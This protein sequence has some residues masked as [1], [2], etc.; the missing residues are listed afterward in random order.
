MRRTT[1]WIALAGLLACGPVTPGSDDTGVGSSTSGGSPT[2]GAA[3]T[4][5]VTT[6]GGETGIAGVTSA[7]PSGDTAGGMSSD[8]FL[9]P[10]DGVVD[11]TCDVFK[12]NCPAGEKCMPYADDGGGS[13][14]NNKCVPVVE[15]PVHL[16]EPCFAPEGGVAGI[17]NCDFGLMCWDV[18]Q[19]GIGY[20][21]EMC[22]GSAEQGL[23]ETP[24][25]VCGVYGGGNLAI[26]LP[27]CNPILQD[28][29]PS[30]VCI[31]NPSGNGFLCVLDASGD[32]GQVH[33]PC[34]F[35]NAC[36]PGL[37]CN[38]PTAAVECDQDAQGCCEPFCDISDPD[39]D[40][41]CPGVG[42][43][44]HPYFEDGTTMPCWQ[45]AGFCAVPG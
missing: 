22:S 40:M 5:G 23:C 18:D 15:D 6:S 32:E 41:K 44:C 45:N 38:D 35:A 36:D 3:G 33:D 42:Q 1:T 26:C 2:T 27:A 43:V 4:N 7:D 14:N 16:G 37:M 20:C 34:N 10:L 8:G 25:T 12:Q 29:D 21:I 9:H 13:W 39:A 11:A 28:C 24:C 30:D 31:G 17:D 19:E